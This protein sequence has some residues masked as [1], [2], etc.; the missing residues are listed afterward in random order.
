MRE[1]AAAAAI[2]TPVTAAN[3]V[4]PAMVAIARRPGRRFSARSQI[5]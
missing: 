5:R 1:N 4:L 2:E 3:T